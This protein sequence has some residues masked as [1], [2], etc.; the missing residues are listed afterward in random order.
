MIYYVNSKRKRCTNLCTCIFITLHIY[1]ILPRSLTN[2]NI[3][4]AMSDMFQQCY[5]KNDERVLYTKCNAIVIV[6]ID[7]EW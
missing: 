1:T 2:A 3:D 6:A 4:I 7:N 5:K